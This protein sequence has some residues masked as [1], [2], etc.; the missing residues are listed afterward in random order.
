MATQKQTVMKQLRPASRV[1]RDLRAALLHFRNSQR[2][3]HSQAF[4]QQGEL[5]SVAGTML[6]DHTLKQPRM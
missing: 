1:A 2:T 4:P 5:P 3:N 6:R